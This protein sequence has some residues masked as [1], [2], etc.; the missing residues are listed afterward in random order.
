VAVDR[1]RKVK[2]LQENIEMYRHQG[3]F[4]EEET[5]SNLVELTGF[6][7]MHLVMDDAI[8]TKLEQ[9]M[10]PPIS[11]FDQEL[12]VTW[13]IPRELKKKKT[14]NGKTFYVLKVIDSNNEVNTIRCWGV[15][16]Q[17][18]KVFLNRPYMANLDWNPQWGFSTRSVRK[19]FKLL[20]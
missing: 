3:S 5:I 7:P 11:E 6:F 16:P 9:M 10:V 1:P 8:K 19:R 15:D 20:A 13:F 4:T 2:N 14:K 17:K 12:K 18:D